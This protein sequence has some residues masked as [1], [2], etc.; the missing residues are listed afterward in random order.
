MLI[1]MAGPPGRPAKVAER[2][3]RA[4]GG[5]AFNGA[6]MNHLVRNYV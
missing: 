5:M 6:R 4:R 3:D 2:D 1:S